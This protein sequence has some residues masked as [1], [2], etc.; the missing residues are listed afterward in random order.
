MKPA[1]PRSLSVVVALTVALGGVAAWR[2]AE[3][4]DLTGWRAA[5]LAVFQAWQEQP[6]SPDPAGHRA[7]PAAPGPAVHPVSG[8]PLRETVRE[9]W[10]HP[11]A[12][13]LVVVPA[14]D[15][16]QGSPDGEAGHF[17]E[18]SPQRRVTVRQPLAVG[19]YPVTRGEYARF[20]ED[21]GYTPKTAC[22]GYAGE[23]ELRK[24][25]RFSWRQPG[26]DQ[27]NQDPAV[28]VGWYDAQAYVAWLG[29]RT[30]QGYR[31]LSEAEWEYA[32]RA[33][34]RSARWWGEAAEA[35]CDAANGADLT[36][37]DR[38]TDWEV[39]NCRDNALFTAPVGSYRPNGFGLY[40]MLGNVWQWVEDCAGDGYPADAA[41]SAAPRLTGD[42][43]R[44]MMRGG[45]WHSN[46]R[47]VRSA[48]RRADRADTG[49]AAYG[50][51]VARELS[52]ATGGASAGRS[53]ALGAV[54]TPP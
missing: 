17:P 23:T 42:C 43:T 4:V 31:L 27:T 8:L 9:I 53:A 24:R 49:Y 18:E 14:G 5:R 11:D 28:C 50:I 30:G 7:P 21:S 3:P 36:A 35:G 13:V 32:A 51:R 41:A 54:G 46:P 48:V 26:F 12:P 33:G 19:K 25:W 2:R 37:K 34:T 44:R 6:G 22:Y 52:S 10:D 45:S 1:L 15:Y 39:A 47:F 20:I 29:R 16:V 38:F 40:D